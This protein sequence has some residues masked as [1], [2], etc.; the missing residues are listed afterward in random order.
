M[1]KYFDISRFLLLLKMEFFKN[2]RG[3]FMA[4]EISF[5]FLFFVGFLFST[6]IDQSIIVYSHQ[7]GY[8]FIM[9]IGGFVMSSLAFG[10]L[11]GSLKRYNYLMLPVSALERFLSMWLLTSIGWIL[12]FTAAFMLYTIIANHIGAFLFRGVTFL[13]FD[14]FGE[15]AITVAK[16]Y[17]V[18]HGIFMVGAVHFRGYVLPKTLFSIILLA[19]LMGA[20]G[21]L[22]MSNGP[23]DAEMEACISETEILDGMPTHRFWQVVVWL[24]W[25]VLAPLCWL[26]TY[27]GIKEQEV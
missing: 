13:P 23:V 19:M 14:P 5:G 3:F 27:L 24:F 12:L 10:E 20:I 16:Y 25:W 26:I 9:L 11:G 4:F 17:F 1:N 18:T 7:E 21:Y 8:A 22:M 15:F 6:A 2:R